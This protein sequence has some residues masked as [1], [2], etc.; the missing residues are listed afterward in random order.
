MASENKKQH[1]FRCLVS[2]AELRSYFTFDLIRAAVEEEGVDLNYDTLRVYLLE[3]TE[4]GLVHSAGKGWYSRFAEALPLDDSPLQA[5]TRSLQAKFP[6]LPVC[7]WNTQQL[8]P[9]LEHLL[10]ISVTFITVEADALTSV[11]EYLKSQGHA[12]VENPRGDVQRKL[13]LE[14]GLVVIRPGVLWKNYTEGPVAPWEVLLVQAWQEANRLGFIDRV[15]FQEMV[16]RALSRGRVQLA[17]LL[18][19]MGKSKIQPKSMFPENDS[20]SEIF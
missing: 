18:A 7:C 19:Y 2:L 16:G 10:G 11:S 20:L 9:Y 14:E 4:K 8:N 6:L 5:I 3:A 1:L 12:V 17:A 15:E 13:S